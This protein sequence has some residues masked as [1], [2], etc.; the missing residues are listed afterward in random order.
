MVRTN[1]SAGHDG[2]SFFGETNELGQ[3]RRSFQSTRSVPGT[4]YAFEAQVDQTLQGSPG[5]RG[6][7]EGSV[8]D[9]GKL[10][11]FAH[12]HFQRT[13]VET[14][15]GLQGPED[16]GVHPAIASQV[17]ILDHL[18]ELRLRHLKPSRSCSDHRDDRKG[19]GLSNGA[20]Q[21]ASG[22]ETSDL[23]ARTQLDPPGA[24]LLRGPRTFDAL[25]TDFEQRS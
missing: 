12:Q 10:G 24:A 6:F 1:S 13:L 4:E 21:L 15:A 2:D 22:R 9:A 20:H 7:V 19:D 16:N 23:Q 11:C 25:H 18:R 14:S 17:D 5:V 8:K 3:L